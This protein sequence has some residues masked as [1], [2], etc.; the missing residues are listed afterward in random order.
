MR[1]VT[2]RKDTFREP[3]LLGAERR[4][5]LRIPHA[6][7]FAPHKRLQERALVEH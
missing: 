5:P 1:F 6:R 7:G 2:E 4:A 3:Q